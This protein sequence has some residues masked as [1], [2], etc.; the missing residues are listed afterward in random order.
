M[1]GFHRNGIALPMDKCCHLVMEMVGV[2][3]DL[4]T[5]RMDEPLNGERHK[6]RSRQCKERFGTAGGVG[7][8]PGAQPCGQN[9]CFHLVYCIAFNPVPC[10]GR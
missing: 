6:G 2:D 1:P 3:H 9:Q 5:P 10:R 7:H 8:Q 4:F